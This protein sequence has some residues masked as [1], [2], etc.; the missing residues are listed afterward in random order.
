MPRGHD[1]VA[2]AEAIDRARLEVLGEHV[3]VRDEA[4]DELAAGIA[5][6]V[7]ADAPLSEV[8][9][10]EGRPD[11]AALGVGD[12]RRRGAP[13]FTVHRMLDLHDV[14][15]EAGE[16]LRRERHRRHLLEREHSYTVERLA[17]LLCLAVPDIT[18]AQRILALAAGG[19]FLGGDRQ[20]PERLDRFVLAL[21]LDASERLDD[22]R[23]TEQR[24]GALADH[25]L[26]GWRE[27]FE[28]RCQVDRVANR[29]E[30]TDVFPADV[31]DERGASVD[32]HP[33]L[34]PIGMIGRDGV[35]RT[36]HGEAGPRR[37]PA[38]L[39]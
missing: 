14:G 20:E 9:P 28:S 10:E 5:P 21:D 4:Q 2:Q 3:E 39:G 11:G 29:G 35:D 34:R 19:R 36:A 17:V 32:A 25:D 1:V 24:S 26:T 7:D 12:R 13:G 38:W 31:A 37:R 23:V 6:K 33:D 8:A 18:Q 27:P 16:H 15:A 30:R 22:G